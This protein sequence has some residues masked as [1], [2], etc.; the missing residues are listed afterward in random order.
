MLAVGFL[1]Q[2]LAACGSAL[3]N[4]NS[5]T[6]LRIVSGSENQTLEP[7]VK[8]FGQQNGVNIQMDYKGSLDIMLMLEDGS[9]NY[10]AI[11]PANSLWISLGDTNKLVKD[12]QSIMRSPVILGVKRS[13][14][15]KLGWVGKDVHVQD[16]L[17]AAENKQLRLMMTSATQSNS[18]ASAYF[19]FLYAFAGNPDVLTSANLQ[20]PAVRAKVKRILATVNRSSESSG[21]LRDLFLKDYDQYDAM[22][23]YESLTIEMNQQLVKSNRE[24]LYAVYPVD[25]LAIADSPLAF[26]NKGNADKE[27]TFLKLQ[28]YMLSTD[29]QNEILGQGRR[30]G[31][32]GLNPDKVDKS[33][34]NPDWGIDVTRVL[35][36][37]KFPSVPVIREALELYQTALRKPSLTTYCLDYSPSMRQNGGYNQL[38][39]AL[40]TV[41]DQQNASKYLLQATPDDVTTALLFAGDVFN[42]DQRDQWTIH[43]NNP[44]DFTRILNMAHAQVANNSTAIYSCVNK[45]LQVTRT[46]VS[47]DRIP[48]VI[49]MTDGQ[50]N[51]G[52]SY[53]DFAQYV[54]STPNDIPVFAITFGDADP[55]ELDRITSLTHGRVY[56]GTKD[57][58]TAFRSAKGNN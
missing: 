15:Q 27:Q 23:N 55:T 8:R 25:G 46:Q 48:A 58:I 41:W 9:I 54:G 22:F 3:G 12:S 39:S 2:S 40:G 34:F 24:P 14:A 11:W 18:G 52:D 37:I 16:I 38:V 13:V 50:N 32:I 47:A 20:D 45:A 5:Q 53:D 21:W 28:Q 36:P 42:Y 31:L 10:D 44:A 35:N 56:D 43:G 19:G 29:V 17:D 30:V 33:V 4:N 6:T 26:V 57:L 7:I 1:V 49:L 51:T